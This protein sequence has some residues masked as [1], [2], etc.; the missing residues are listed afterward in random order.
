MENRE[1]SILSWAVR[2]LQQR[3]NPAG[4][5]YPHQQLP[6]ANACRDIGSRAGMFRGAV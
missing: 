4:K 3:Q 5:V 1:K 2:A 6:L